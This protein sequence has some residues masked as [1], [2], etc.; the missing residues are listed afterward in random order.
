MTKLIITDDAA[1]A[2]IRVA[3]RSAAPTTA[4][5]ED[6]YLD[7]GTNTSSG[8]PGWR[9]YT[10]S[11]WEDVSAASGGSSLPIADTTGVV[12]GSADASKIIRMEADGLTTA[13]TRVITMP[14]ADVDLADV[15]DLPI[16][17]LADGTDGELI[18]WD[19]A[20]APAA[21]GVGTSGQVLTSNGAG[22]APTFQAAGGSTSIAI[23]TDEKT[24]TTDGGACSA[25]T[26]NARDLNTEQ[27][28]PDGIA[29]ISSNKFTP[30]SGTYRIHAYA[31]AHKCNRHRLRL[32]NVTGAAVV[33][34]GASSYIN[35]AELVQVP[36]H[37][38]CR[39]TANGT[40]EYRIDHYTQSAQTG[41]GLGE[42]TNDGSP[43]IYLVIVL[44]Q[45]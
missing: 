1:E 19:A 32:Y 25:A 29:T 14:D 20:G 34:E 16:A 31:P 40:D 45:E 21:V 43:E 30:A 11:V 17:N 15:N 36:A 9:R 41:N 35:S 4:V 38:H 26:W 13:T 2:P 24:T 7:D 5:T 27:S 37:L 22:A 33:Q 12:K 3:E 28:D 8:N 44:E 6:I 23:L 42:A 10:G 18:T 39:F